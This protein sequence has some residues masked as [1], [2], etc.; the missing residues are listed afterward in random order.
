MK[1]RA[2]TMTDVRQFTSPV[3]VAGI[4]DGL[5]VLAAAN[6]SGKSTLFDAIHAVFFIPHRSSKIGPLRPDVGGNP[7][8][9]IEI[10]QDGTR[11]LLRKRWG[12]GALAEV[13]RAGRL[14][15]KGDEAEAFISAL[16]VAP[17][18]GGPAG[19]L[20]V[21]QGLT[22]LDQGSK[23][24]Q[25]FAQT[26]RRDLMTSVTGEF[27]ALTG[28][29][30]MD[31]ALARARAEHDQLMTQ[32]GAKAGG[33]YDAALKHLAALE[34]RHTELT[35][36]AQH[37]RDALDQRRSKRRQLA[38]VSDPAEVRE[39]TK[40]LAE[41]QAAFV[42]A[43]RHAEALRAT[44]A[45][46]ASAELARDAAVQAQGT[47]NRAHQAVDALRKALVQ[48]EA[49]ADQANLAAAATGA[50]L[51]EATTQA[52]AL[53]EARRVADAQLQTALRAAAQQA[54]R[55][56]HKDLS[57]ALALAQTRAATVPPLREAAVLGPDAKAA[58]AIDEA[59]R[60]W[61]LAE[62][63]A[64]AAAPQITLEYVSPHTP[65]AVL[66]GAPVE[67][68][69]P[70]LEPTTLNLPGYARM[71]IDP[72]RRANDATTLTKARDRLARLLA[73]AGVASADEARTAAQARAAA[74][75]ALREALADLNRLAPEGIEALVAEVAR[76]APSGADS[77]APDT[78]TAQAT[79]NAAVQAAEAAD[80]ALEAARAKRDAATE[81]KLAATH[82]LAHLRQRL[83]EAET[84]LAA[85][86]EA[87]TL[88]AD[89]A[90]AEAAWTEA[91]AQH[92]AL[93]SDAPD[94]AACTATLER[95]KD[96]MRRAEEEI[97][98]IKAALIRLDTQIEI[99]AGDGVDEDLAEVTEQLIAARDTCEAQAREVAVL[100][101]LIEALETA[102][103]AARD[104][105]FAPVLTELR[106]MLRL[107]WPEAEL[108]F[109]GDSLLPSALVRDGHSESIG[110]LSGGTR[111]QIALLVRLAFA[112][113]LARSGRHAPVILDDALVYTDD[114]R[115]EQM[116]TALHAQSNDLQILV[117]SCRNR[118]LRALGGRKLTLEPV[119][120]PSPA[121]A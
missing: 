94:L 44:E 89:Q 20:W 41:A 60:A 27:E 86:P 30:R 93:A 90:Q 73:Q 108:R 12:R 85:Q 120:A 99:E 10:E 100:K 1:L 77:E 21:K 32:R 103:S 102:Q 98:Q 52:A 29:K 107:L 9:T 4:G 59:H 115:I 22:A 116:F 79:A 57:T 72:G 97:G 81:V 119:A 33:A 61:Q 105:Y 56:R 46:L 51:A 53:R 42:A 80:L 96:V 15:A 78:E 65:R 7:D 88:A 104:R 74:Q 114:E 67:G 45:R 23:K 113:L 58:Q 109:D 121:E 69:T 117:F 16:T 55:A 110:T 84:A 14:I 5:N 48:A 25:E 101:T 28:G 62:G 70:V 49:K 66:D 6:E 11:H 17:E 91:H 95:A 112:R 75:A 71:T 64:T 47:R 8:I 39:R 38:D 13:S 118:A 50:R 2:I 34:T 18:D 3:Q 24:E 35:A 19:L 37:L 82:E 68:P 76:I 43:D 40:R 31:H 106:P 92:S 87:A 36:K 63:L 83:T 54:N 111:E 26:A